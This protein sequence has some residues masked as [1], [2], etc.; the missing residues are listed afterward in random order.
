MPGR[1]ILSWRHDTAPEAELTSS[2]RLIMLLSLLVF[3]A[4][5]RTADPSRLPPT[6]AETASLD[7][8]FTGIKQ[9]SRESFARDD[10][11]TFAALFPAGTLACWN[12]TG[13][14]H[15]YGFL[16]I[17]PVPDS[18]S[19]TVVPIRGY[20]YGSVDTTAMHASHFMK[21]TY[22]SSYPSVCEPPAARRW[23]ELHY[24]LR[25][26]AGVFRL[27]HYCPLRDRVAQ[28][29]SVASYWPMLTL[30]QA[31]DIVGQMSTDEEE[32][33][34]GMV[35]AGGSPARA[36]GEIARRYGIWENE[37]DLVLEQLCT[38]SP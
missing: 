38:A 10:W 9:A 5:S 22:E 26:E 28:A 20:E 17:R 25:R 4:C 31:R 23:P 3:A 24:Y 34:R 2:I 11:S 6:P 7:A 27:T 12:T 16:S 29:G 32:S 8:I 13:E 33:Y 14:D 36:E 15:R 30:S 21:I 1:Q 18:A 35:R 19:Y 37:A